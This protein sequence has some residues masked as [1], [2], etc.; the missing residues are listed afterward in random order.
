M[1]AIFLNENSPRPIPP[2]PSKGT[3]WGSAGSLGGLGGTGGAPFPF[4]KKQSTPPETRHAYQ[5][6]LKDGGGGGVYITPDDLGLARQE[7]LKRY[8]EQLRL[9]SKFMVRG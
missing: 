8:G 2:K 6:I 3:G 1:A 4:V 5:Y 7:L 9:V